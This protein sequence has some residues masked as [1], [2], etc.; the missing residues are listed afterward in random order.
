MYISRSLL[1][2]PDFCGTGKDVYKRQ[3]DAT[4][5]QWK[6]ENGV[7]YFENN[8]G[9]YTGWI[10]PDGN[11]YYMDPAAGGAMVSN[12]AMVIDGV[13]YSFNGSGVMQ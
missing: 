13:T 6:E 7:W 9:R 2:G 8:G 12:T 4:P 3:G 10:R 11:W 5:G 1:A